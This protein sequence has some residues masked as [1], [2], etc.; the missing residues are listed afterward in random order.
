MF[1]F[2]G[3]KKTCSLLFIF[4][5]LRLFLN[6]C[7]HCFNKQLFHAFSAKICTLFYA[8]LFLHFWIFVRVNFE[9]LF[10]FSSLVPL[11]FIKIA[12]NVIKKSY[13][14]WRTTGCLEI[15][16]LLNGQFFFFFFFPNHTSSMPT[17]LTISILFC[18]TFWTFVVLTL[19]NFRILK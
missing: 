13:K 18:S 1:S 4:A 19:D 8:F 11:F 16:F 12:E 15:K 3:M 9:L 6:F 17:A 10:G 5:P 2:C 7:I 14:V